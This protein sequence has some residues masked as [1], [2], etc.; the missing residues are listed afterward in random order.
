M[1]SNVGHQVRPLALLVLRGAFMASLVFGHVS[2]GGFAPRQSFQVNG[3][4]VTTDDHAQ[5]RVVL[6]PG[7]Y[8]VTYVDKNGVTWTATI[9]S[10]SGPLRQDI[11]LR[12]K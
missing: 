3:K 1:L 10:D 2:G 12:K 11:V 6:D 5:Y 9:T 7:R 4:T 8:D